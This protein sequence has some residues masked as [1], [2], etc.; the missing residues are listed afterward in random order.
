MRPNAP[1]EAEVQPLSGS[2]AAGDP[3]R[4]PAGSASESGAG[5]A[6]IAAGLTA[7]LALAACAPSSES[8]TPLPTAFD[9]RST[10]ADVDLLRR[11]PALPAA[12]APAPPPLSDPSALLDWAEHMYPQH[13]PGHRPDER[14]DPYLYRYYPATGNYVGVAG[15]DVYVLG[16]LSGGELM[17]VGTLADFTSNVHSDVRPLHAEDMAAARLL[18]QAQFSASEAEIAHVRAIGAAA[19]LAEQTAA[20]RGRTAVQYMDQRGCYDT[21]ARKGMYTNLWTAQWAAWNQMLT[22]TDAVRVRATVSLSEYFVVSTLGVG[23][24]WGSYAVATFWDTLAEH[25]FGNFRTLLEKVTLSLAMGM[26]LNTAYNRKEDTTSGREP[27]ENY[28]REV[29]QLFTIGLY[30]LN[31]DGTE[32]LGPHGRPIETYTNHD[33]TNLARVFTGYEPAPNRDPPLSSD[34]P[35]NPILPTRTSA[36]AP[37]VLVPFWHSTL[38]CR[39]LGT[40]IP[41]GTDGT[42]ALKMALDTLFRHPNVGPFFCRQMIQ[43]LVVSNPSPAYVRRVAAVFDDNGK[44]ERGDLRAV[45]S[46]IWLDPEARGTGTT[47]ASR[48]GKLREPILRLAQWGRTFASERVRNRWS[49]ERLFIAMGVFL[50]QSPLYSPSVFNFFRPGYVPPGTP[51][52]AQGWV[53]PEFQ[54]IDEASTAIFLN[55]MSRAVR[56]GI[57]VQIHDEV[58]SLQGEY[59]G[60]PQEWVPAEC[61]QELPLAPYAGALVRRLNLLMCAGQLPQDVQGMMIDALNA[62]TVSADS[63]QDAKLD[64]IAAAMMMVLACPEYIVQH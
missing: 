6:A 52:A 21:S 17:R 64:R 35:R 13:F 39:F 25:A 30:E 31:P 1:S 59:V 49:L 56:M 15:Q 10:A 33:V 2:A 4:S 38:E 42:V 44:G 18:L 3:P 58:W 55:F 28:A 22:S 23:G 41:A 9:D 62:T 43:R 19:W 34:D 40:V 61:E 11:T 47:E 7:S 37:M 27:D 12:S 48:L 20:P 50:N 26:Y 46:A 45:F 8:P 63:S 29:M 16:P 51:M 57:A 60:A 14:A 5:A 24:H 54:I 53:A 32:K 36:I